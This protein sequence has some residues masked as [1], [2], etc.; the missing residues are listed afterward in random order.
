MV[1]DID[2][3]DVEFT[4]LMGHIINDKNLFPAMG[5]LFFLWQMMASLKKQKYINV[6]IVFE[7]VNFIRATILSQQ[8]EI[9]LTLL[10]QE[11]NI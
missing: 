4:Y 11:G 1:I 3:H 7:N 5:Y 6:P 9:E 10:I 2:V 8:N